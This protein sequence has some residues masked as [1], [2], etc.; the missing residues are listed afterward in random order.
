MD[1]DLTKQEK[2]TFVCP[3]CGKSFSMVISPTNLELTPEELQRKAEEKL[4]R[5]A[6]I[7]AY[8]SL[9]YIAASLI[10]LAFYLIGLVG[11]IG[12]IPVTAAPAFLSAVVCLYRMR[13][14]IVRDPIMLRR[15]TTCKITAFSDPNG[16]HIMKTREENW[17][18]NLFLKK[19][20]QKPA[21]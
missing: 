20:R 17:S 15:E 2:R 9:S 5:Q 12:I 1:I 14:P 6:K 10:T 16:N 19:A 11:D 21:E 8:F 4:Q 18:R 13:H 7:M 3:S